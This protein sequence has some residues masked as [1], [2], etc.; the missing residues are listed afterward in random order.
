MKRDLNNKEKAGL[1]AIKETG[2]SYEVKYFSVQDEY[3]ANI[4]AIK[5]TWCLRQ[6][7]T[8]WIEKIKAL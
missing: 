3:F 8:K 4:P 7:N 1:K 2:L 5:E 6:V